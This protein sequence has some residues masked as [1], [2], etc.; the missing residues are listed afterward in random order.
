MNNNPDKNGEGDVI[1]REDP[2]IVFPNT[3]NQT[4][5]SE[6]TQLAGERGSEIF[7][8]VYRVLDTANGLNRRTVMSG[9]PY[10]T[11]GHQINPKDS[12]RCSHCNKLI[13]PE[14]SMEYESESHCEDCFRIRHFNI[15]KPSF[16]ILLC[17]EHGIMDERDINELTR[18]PKD[19]IKSLTEDLH[20]L[21]IREKVLFGILKDKIQLSDTG[22]DALY[23]YE[24]RYG[25]ER[26]VVTIK[27]RIEQILLRS[28]IQKQTE[29]VIQNTKIARI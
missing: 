13:C 5:G 24:K 14:C 2:V 20:G 12:K 9:V 4:I 23:S 1:E 7:S 26:D 21:I 28:S 10:C 6:V 3:N 11:C 19:R 22:R 17:M 27:N 8:N 29:N 15:R 18:I 16:L 25:N